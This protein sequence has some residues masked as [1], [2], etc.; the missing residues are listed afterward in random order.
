MSTFQSVFSGSCQLPTRGSV[1]TNGEDR[2]SFRR[3]SA[4]CHGEQGKG[5]GKRRE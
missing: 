3:G 1:E 2:A 4:A 5:K